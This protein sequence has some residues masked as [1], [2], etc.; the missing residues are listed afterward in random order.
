MQEDIFRRI[1]AACERVEAKG[2]TIYPGQYGVAYDGKRKRWTPVRHAEKRMCPL[3][4]LVV[5]EQPKPGEHWSVPLAAF[6]LLGV[7]LE[8]VLD[9][10]VTFD[11]VLLGLPGDGADTARATLTWLAERS[12]AGLP[13]SPAEPSAPAKTEAAEPR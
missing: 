4:A 1:Q 2:Y 6:I 13:G 5:V 7:S 11:G 3:G 8:W 10:Q 9:F 12:P